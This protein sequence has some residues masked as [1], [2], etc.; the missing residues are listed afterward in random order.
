MTTAERDALVATEVMGWLCD[1]RDG[2]LNV[3]PDI[4]KPGRP[5]SPST[6]IRD[7]MEALEELQKN[8]DFANAFISECTC[9]ASTT[10]TACV[11]TLRVVTDPGKL[12][13]AMLR[14]KEV[15]V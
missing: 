1:V 13:K 15:D 5:W 14:S 8:I 3:W 4:E 6:D 11:Y 9:L 2:K 7:A 10:R 12:C